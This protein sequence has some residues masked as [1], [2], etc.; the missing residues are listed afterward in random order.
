MAG[1]AVHWVGEFLGL[2]EPAIGAANLAEA[3]P[4]MAG[5]YFVPAMVGLGAPHWDP[6]A[7]GLLC[8]LEQSHTAAHLAQAAVESI[9]Y[10]VADVF[11]TMREISGVALPVLRA[12]GGATRNGCLM[13]FQADLLGVPVLRSSNEDLSA[14]GA[15]IMGGLA[16]G[17]WGDLGVVAELPRSFDMF[18]PVW[19]ETERRSRYKGW[20]EAVR[21]TRLAPLAEIA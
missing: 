21:R 11:F 20:Q 16:L 15:A 3:V 6:D 1:A 19:S 7:R 9:A 10:Q 18:T 8:G 13:Q 5:M 12:D 14:L 17:W 4:D 2:R